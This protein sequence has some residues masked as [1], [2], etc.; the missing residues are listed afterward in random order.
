MGGVVNKKIDEC[1]SVR[2]KCTE[3]TWDGG[4]LHHGQFSEI[5]SLVL[6][7]SPYGRGKGDRD[8]YDQNRKLQQ[9]TPNNTRDREIVATTTQNASRRCSNAASGPTV[10]KMHGLGSARISGKSALNGLGTGGRGLAPW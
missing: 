1:T 6:E 3:W 2:K 10:A 5:S 8:H 7:S 4:G 9:N